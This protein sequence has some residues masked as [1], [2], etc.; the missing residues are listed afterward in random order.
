MERNYDFRKRLE[1]V[2]KPNRRDSSVR[3]EAGELEISEDWRIVIDEAASPLLVHTAKDLQDYPFV[4][5]KG[6][7]GNGCLARAC[8]RTGDERAIASD[9]R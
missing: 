4:A 3:A 7:G 1:V 2:H 6:Y 8:N 5:G 9:W